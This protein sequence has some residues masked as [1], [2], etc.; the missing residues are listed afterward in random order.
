MLCLA[1]LLSHALLLAAIT[2][3]DKWILIGIIWGF[4][5]SGLHGVHYGIKVWH[6]LKGHEPDMSAYVTR[7]EFNEAKAARDQQ[8]KGSIDAIQ[9]LL[10]GLRNDLRALTKEFN[11]ERATLNRALGRVEGHDERERQ[12][13]PH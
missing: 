2:D 4:V 13:F 8:L 3:G 9:E 6:Q 5:V 10:K 11:D 1:A 7:A 12:G